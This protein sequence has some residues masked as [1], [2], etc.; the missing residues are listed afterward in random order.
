MMACLNTKVRLAGKNRM[1]VSERPIMYLCNHRSWAD[2]FVD[3]YLL[4]GK[5]MIMSRCPLPLHVSAVQAM[6]ALPRSR[7]LPLQAPP[8]SSSILLPGVLG[9]LSSLPSRSSWPRW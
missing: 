5:A 9:W 1:A 6:P 4:G 2:F 3:V 7:R 8:H